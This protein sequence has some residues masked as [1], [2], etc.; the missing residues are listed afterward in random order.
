[1]FQFDVSAS[2]DSDADLP[3]SEQ[4]PPVSSSL[5]SA[6]TSILKWS[7]KFG[8][9]D[10]GTS[11]LF[12]I[13]RKSFAVIEGS[14]EAHNLAGPGIPN[15]LGKA[16][17]MVSTT[18]QPKISELLVCPACLSVYGDW[19]SVQ[20][21]Q[22]MHVAAPFHTHA[23]R[24]ESCGAD[25][26][27][28]GAVRRPVLV[29]PYVS[30]L[31]SLKAFLGRPG[32]LEACRVAT[33]ASSSTT[34]TLYCDV[35]DGQVWKEFSTVEDTPFLGDLSPARLNLALQLNVDWFQPFKHTVFSVGAIY[36][37]ILN[38]PRHLRY[39][40]ENTILVGVIPGPHEPSLHTNS[41]L[42]PFVSELLQLWDGITL[43]GTNLMQPVT[44]R[45]AL[46]SVV[47]D[48]PGLAKV[49]GFLGH[50][51]RL[52]C[53]KCM[54]PFP[55]AHFGEKP[56]YSGY[57]RDQWPKRDIATHRQLAD[58]YLQ[59]PNRSQQK[60]FE[61][62][63][64]LRYSELLKLPYFD[65]IR[66]CVVDPMHNLFLGSARHFIEVV[67]EKGILTKV[68]MA[69]VEER[70]QAFNS[71][72]AVGR[73]PRKVASK[74]AGFKA[75]QWRNW[76]V[77]FSEVAYKGILPVP[78]FNCWQKFVK[79]IKLLCSHAISRADIIFADALLQEYCEDF[80]QLFGCE[81]CT[82][83]MHKHL[84]LKKCM[85]DF[86]PIYSF[87]CFPFE[88]FNGQLESYH[89]NSKNIE[90][91]IARKFLRT[92][93]VMSLPTAEQEPP[94]SVPM[95]P[96]SKEC[97]QRL[98]HLQTAALPLSTFAFSIHDIDFRTCVDIDTNKVKHVCLSAA[99]QQHLLKLYETLYGHITIIFLAMEIKKVSRISFAGQ[100]LRAS[101]N[102]NIVSAIWPG[103]ENSMQLRVGRI[104]YFF[105]HNIKCISSTPSEERST[106]HLQHLLAKVHFFQQHPQANYFNNPDIIVSFN[107]YDVN[108]GHYT[109]MPLQRL[110]G[111]CACGT[112]PLSFDSS[113]DTHNVLVTNT[114]PFNFTVL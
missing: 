36:V 42:A 45:A 7:A 98:L 2:D 80:E 94:S 88:R 85:F 83:N 111:V 20:A 10:T 5:R 91:Q 96:I 102:G 69:A 61:S 34:A 73:L 33:E 29:Y 71:P 79:A 62:Q 60:A 22:C 112:L 9:S 43:S 63:H 75:D 107:E 56:N 72:H 38:L 101:E 21:S 54:K 58:E 104:I 49:A 15:S 103:T 53:S 87:W 23:T 55:T 68:E 93:A 67:M 46:L 35:Y 86:G 57:D 108:M 89:T 44:V 100:P 28:P 109:F 24:R 78:Y 30:L 99:D 59:L 13:L 25:L 1:M 27:Q 81:A 66:Y 70:V 11:E 76:T 92:Q 19:H 50:G 17:E 4:V 31:E 77:I 106:V 51:A 6:V 8:T 114:L 3:T 95:T 48:I 90:V 64:G 82:I 39:K 41:F 37:S 16:I 47:C 105:T 110:T 12:G 74:F 26:F 113:M 84:H 40:V 52:S 65:I 14:G 18:R 97:Y 32:F